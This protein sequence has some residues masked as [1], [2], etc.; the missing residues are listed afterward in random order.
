MLQSRAR[1]Y[2]LIALDATPDVLDRLL[3]GVTD[4]AAYDSRLAP[5]QFTLREILAHLADWTQIYRD[6]LVQ[7][8]DMENASLPSYDE[9]QLAVDHNYAQADPQASLQRFRAGR[10]ELLS[11]L[12]GLSADQ[13]NRSAIHSEYG[14]LTVDDQ[15]ALIAGHD[16]YHL[17]EIARVLGDGSR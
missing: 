2:L 11:V 4:S 10:Q 12:N 16:G 6:R 9:G 17:Q 3:A 15:L 1:S 13:W 8:R 14:S 7:T 5:D